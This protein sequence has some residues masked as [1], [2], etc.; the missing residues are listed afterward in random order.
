M[1][2]AL[3][4]TALLWLPSFGNEQNVSD[5]DCGNR[6]ATQAVA[7]TQRQQGIHHATA[8]WRRRMECVG[9]ARDWSAIARR[10]RVLIRV[11]A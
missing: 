6:A 3:I 10:S 8:E 1:S 4:V 7:A 5:H 2:E 9:C 11:P